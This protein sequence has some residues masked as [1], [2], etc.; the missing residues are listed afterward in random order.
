MMIIERSYH[1]I[2]I[3]Q[4][5]Y[6]FGLDIKMGCNQDQAIQVLIRIFYGEVCLIGFY[7]NY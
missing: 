2:C 7:I 5:N 1:G 4:S 3:E 6:P